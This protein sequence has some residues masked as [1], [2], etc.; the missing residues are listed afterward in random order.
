MGVFSVNGG[1]DY[2]WGIFIYLFIIYGIIYYLWGWDYFIYGMRLVPT[3]DSGGPPKGSDILQAFEPRT[4]AENV[5]DRSNHGRSR[6]RRVNPSRSL[7]EVKVTDDFCGEERAMIL[8]LPGKH[9]GEV[10]PN[11]SPKMNMVYF[12]RPAVTLLSRYGWMKIN[13]KLWPWRICH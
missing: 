10:F 9:D 8:H 1:W 5:R 13:Q 7:P 6:W 12:S 4:A 11:E 2:L 3:Y